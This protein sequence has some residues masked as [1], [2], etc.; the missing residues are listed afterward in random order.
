MEKEVAEINQI[1]LI[2][3]LKDL[4]SSLIQNIKSNQYGDQKL[5]EESLEKINQLVVKYRIPL[6]SQLITQ[7]KVN[8]LVELYYENISS[9]LVVKLI[10]QVLEIFSF[11]MISDSPNSELITKCSQYGIKVSIPKKRNELTKEE[12]LYDM[13]MNLKTYWFIL[14]SIS[15]NEDNIEQDN[16]PALHEQYQECKNIFEEVKK[17]NNCTQES[18]VFYS[19][20]LS[21]LNQLDSCNNNLNSNVVNDFSVNNLENS[22]DINNSLSS[23]VV[24]IVQNNISSMK[25]KNYVSDIELKKRKFFYLKENLKEPEGTEVEYKDYYFPLK[26]QQVEELKRQ[27]CGFL[28]SKGGRIFIGV[29]DLKVV[30]GIPL[31]YKQKD[32]IRN[33]IINFTYDFY[34]KCRTKKFQVVYVPIKNFNTQQFINNMYIIKIIVPQGDT[35]KLY[36]ICNKGGFI[37]FFRLS[38]QCA[39]FTAEEIY[40]E[41][42]KRNKKPGDKID[43]K[44][45][46]DPEPE[47][48]PDN[49]QNGKGPSNYG[50]W[51]S[52][53][54][55]KGK[56]GK[57]YSVKV[58]GISTQTTNKELEKLFSS[59]GAS[60]M[61]FFTDGKTNKANKANKGGYGF[62]NFKTLEE[63]NKAIKKYNGY[64]L[65]GQKIELKIKDYK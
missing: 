6:A 39:N 27:I 59:L 30:K 46:E 60:S 43:E 11:P 10:N 52:Y 29:T 42:I 5:V 18:L 57:C 19:D 32:T 47:Q 26:T 7:D 65:K 3:D 38:G 12:K 49:D 34:P 24:S 41:I 44:E 22:M 23:S 14:K 61:R 64:S 31:N 63:A 48:V 56:N 16:L 54:M 17:D 55:K 50:G 15:T 25:I 62:L 40:E 28:N 20:L 33:E 13:I 9:E 21:E 2:P 4:L 58:K 8:F 37:S 36:S 45:F 35:D 1:Y 53:P 51:S